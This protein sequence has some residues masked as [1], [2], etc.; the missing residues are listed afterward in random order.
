MGMGSH[1]LW[2]KFTFIGGDTPFP[3]LSAIVLLDDI[4]IGYYDTID[5]TVVNRGT[6]NPDTESVTLN[7]VKQIFEHVF[8]SQ[9][10]TGC[11]ILDDGQPGRLISRDAFNG[12]T[13]DVRYY[14]PQLN[15]LHTD[16]VWPAAVYS[17]WPSNFHFLYEHLY[18]PACISMLQK[19]LVNEKHRVLKKVKPKVRLL[20]KEVQGPTV[21]LTCLATGFYPRHINLTLL[22]D[23][24]PVDDHQITGGQLLPNG[25]ET[26]QMRKSLE[27][28]AEE[29][30]QHHYTCRAQHL[31]L[32]NKL[33]TNLGGRCQTNSSSTTNSEEMEETESITAAEKHTSLET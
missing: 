25:D 17:N 7:D 23:G 14:N 16:H 6:K 2:V 4:Q 18:H 30:H 24:Q 13:G 26:Y 12:E 32:P 27:V 10:I 19:H 15:T 1:S 9:R 33:D 21:L 5:N 8:V 28:S 29:L 31:S 11:E 3:E 20:Q 22:R